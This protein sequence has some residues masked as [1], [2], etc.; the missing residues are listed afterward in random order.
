MPGEEGNVYKFLII[1]IIITDNHIMMASCRFV[2]DNES[3]K[4]K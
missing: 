2:R 1:I 3:I 4:P